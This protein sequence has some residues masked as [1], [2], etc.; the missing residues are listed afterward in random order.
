MSEDW[1]IDKHGRWRSDA[2]LRWVRTLRCSCGN[3]MC[4]VCNISHGISGG[5]SSFSTR[6][7]AAHFRYGASV[8]MSMKPDDFMVYPLC[9]FVHRQFHTSGH[10]SASWQMERVVQT[11]RLAFQRGILALDS[12]PREAFPF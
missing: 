8:G 4:P 5:F 3:S 9:S 11:M 12:S 1:S 6:T 7:E 2:Y 10:P